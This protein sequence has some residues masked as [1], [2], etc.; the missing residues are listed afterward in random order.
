MINDIS[1]KSYTNSDF[2]S[3]LSLLVDSFKSKFT[4]RQTLSPESIKLILSSV[5]E[6]AEHEPGC[7]HLVAHKDQK[8]AGVIF[9]RYGRA[10]EGRKRVPFLSLC[11]RFGFIQVT[12]LL[13]KLSILDHSPASKCYVEHIAVDASLR[14][15]G[16]GEML[17]SHAENMLREKKFKHLYLTVARNNPAKHLYIRNGF[18]DIKIMASPLKG[19]LIG[20]SNWDFMRKD[21]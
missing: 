4:F 16:I 15:A 13:L 19:F 18:E 3:V 20:I 6:L 10:R 21:L 2:S 14:G 11:H 8:I 12:L 17:L 9:V 5:W 7:L 1:I